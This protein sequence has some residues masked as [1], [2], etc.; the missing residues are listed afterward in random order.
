MKHT[1]YWEPDRWPTRTVRRWQ[2]KKSRKKVGTS[3]E[4]SEAVTTGGEERPCK[5]A[6][7]M[8][9]SGVRGSSEGR[10]LSAELKTQFACLRGELMGMRGELVAMG[11]CLEA[12]EEAVAAGGE[13][14]AT[15]KERLEDFTEE[16]TSFRG[17]LEGA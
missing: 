5:R 8:A 7:V 6:R 9:G 15:I 16:F 3:D 17:A 12:I 14:A 11:K 10:G 13:D 4:E 2:A 1:C